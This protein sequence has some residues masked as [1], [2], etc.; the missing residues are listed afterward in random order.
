MEKRKSILKVRKP[1]EP[2]EETKL[3]GHGRYPPF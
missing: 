2:K 3:A 1:T